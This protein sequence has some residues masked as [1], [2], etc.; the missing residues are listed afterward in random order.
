M[1]KFTTSKGEYLA[2]GVPEMSGNFNMIKQTDGHFRLFWDRREGDYDIIDDYDEGV[3]LPDGTYDFIAT[4]DTL[5]EEQA[6]EIVGKVFD[7]CQNDEGKGCV[8]CSG[9]GKGDCAATMKPQSF[10]S[11]LTSLGVEGR[12]AILKVI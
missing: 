9:D 3:N 5:T 2:V 10:K 8:G 4:S 11:L 12:V 6:A 7:Y 1:T